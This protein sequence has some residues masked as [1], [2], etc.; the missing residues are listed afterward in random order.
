MLVNMA[1]HI[2][3]LIM[4]I[5]GLSPIMDKNKLLKYY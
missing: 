3:I 2:I 5:Q 4:A 1:I